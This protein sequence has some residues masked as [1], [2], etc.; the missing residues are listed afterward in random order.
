MGSLDG[1][2]NREENRIF[3]PHGLILVS[4]NDSVQRNKEE[5]G[6]KGTI[7][8]IYRFFC[9]GE[10]SLQKKYILVKNSNSTEMYKIIS[11]ENI[12]VN[13]LCIFFWTFSHI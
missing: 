11:S 4:W 9:G 10:G 12:A 3:S 13:G 2:G 5:V 8:Y 7:K 6:T 1:E